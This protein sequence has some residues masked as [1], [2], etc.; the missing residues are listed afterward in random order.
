MTPCAHV[1][2]ITM[3]TCMQLQSD[4]NARVQ[5]KVEVRLAR[6]GKLDLAASIG[7]FLGRWPARRGDQL[8]D[9]LGHHGEQHVVENT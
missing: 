9:G 3:H 8:V 2:A 1:Y 5:R 4:Y 7:Q 6:C